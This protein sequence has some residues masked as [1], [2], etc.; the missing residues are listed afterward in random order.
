MAWLIALLAVLPPFTGYVV[1]VPHAIPD[2]Q[3]VALE[4]QCAKFE[5][6]GLGQVAVAV[7][8]D[9][10]TRN[11]SEY[12][13]ALFH[14]WGIGA[15]GLDDGLLIL[16]VPGPEGHRGVKIEVGY[17]LE[18]TLPDGKVGAIL[19]ELAGPRLR[20]A[21]YGDAA[22]ALVERFAQEVEASI[23]QG[24]LS[25]HRP[26]PR[27][28]V[29]ARERSNLGAD[30]VRKSRGLLFHYGWWATVLF[31]GW[32]LFL[33]DRGWQPKYLTL[34][35]VF[36]AAVA[37]TAQAERADVAF[38]FGAFPALLFAFVLLRW[39][40]CRKCG[41]YVN[42]RRESE[43]ETRDKD[44]WVRITLVCASCKNEVLLSYTE[45][46]PLIAARIRKLTEK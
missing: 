32:L 46:D 8:S 29:E 1:D 31:V 21:A 10:G 22:Q 5:S 39:S 25:R 35:L 41:G 9:L 13:V 45:N 15:H 27:R 11:K 18:G 7:I 43:D 17:G 14:A 37:V 28:S 4:Q 6:D 3:R 44:G 33:Q 16:L 19:D 36:V 42:E 30:L 26:L 24:N 38:V 12:A 34:T 23:A 40:R 20:Q 2:A